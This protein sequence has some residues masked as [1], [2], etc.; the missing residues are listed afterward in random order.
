[1]LNEKGW[2]EWQNILSD[3]DEILMEEA[4][5]SVIAYLEKEL[6]REFPEFVVK[7]EMLPNE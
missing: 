1:M 3:N 6:P 4:R 5:D 7:A 2:E